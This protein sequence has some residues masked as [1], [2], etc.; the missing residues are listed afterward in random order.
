M[1]IIG[2]PTLSPR[3]M[4]LT[5]QIKGQW[6]IIL[7]DTGNPRNFMDIAV[8]TKTTSPMTGFGLEVRIVDG[9]V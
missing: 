4:R 2:S 1:L 6:I 3:T 5:S 8:V 7:V 9:S